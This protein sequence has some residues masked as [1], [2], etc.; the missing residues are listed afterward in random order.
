MELAGA[1]DDD[2]EAPY[3]GRFDAVIGR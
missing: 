1:I 2:I 3:L